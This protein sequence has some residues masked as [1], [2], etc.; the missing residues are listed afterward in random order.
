MISHSSRG[1]RFLLRTG[2]VATT[3][4]IVGADA[5]VIYPD[6]EERR[7]EFADQPIRVYEGELRISVKF[8]SSPSNP[9]TGRLTY[10]AC[11]D[12]ACLPPVTKQFDVAATQQV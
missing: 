1:G 4:K 11:T 6:G 5:E 9:L 3:L 7:F 12:T 2:L 10:Q 8:T